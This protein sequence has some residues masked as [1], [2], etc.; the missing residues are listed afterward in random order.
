M[1]DRAERPGTYGFSLGNM[2]SIRH[3][4]RGLET[5]TTNSWAMLYGTLVMGAIALLRGDNFMPE[6]TVSYLGA[7]LYLALFGSVIAFGA[8]FTSLGASA[9]AKPPTVRCC[10][11]W[12]P[13]PFPPSMKGMSGTATP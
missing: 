12:S 5:L 7:L 6:W 1:G 3:Q 13:Y 9:P 10:F 4:R 2:F 11:R 8:Y